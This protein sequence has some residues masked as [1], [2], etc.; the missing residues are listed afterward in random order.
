MSWVVRSISS[1]QRAQSYRPRSGWSKVW[2]AS[3]WRPT[4]RRCRSPW[5]RTLRPRQKKVAGTSSASRAS[6]T[7][8]VQSGCG[9][10]SKVNAT[11][12]WSPGPLQTTRCPCRG[13]WGTVRAD[14]ADGTAVEGQRGGLVEVLLHA[15]SS[16]RSGR[17]HGR[18]G[19]RGQ[20]LPACH[21]HGS[22]CYGEG[23]SIL[24]RAGRGACH[25]GALSGGEV[26][27]GSRGGGRASCRAGRR[28][29]RGDGR[30]RPRPAARGG[31]PP[32]PGP[33]QR[34][35]LAH[36][37][38]A[39]RRR[40]WAAGSSTPWRRA[41]GSPTGRCRPLVRAREPRRRPCVTSVV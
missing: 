7:R 29:C 30:P 1:R 9:P 25:T 34:R 41:S 4:L 32:P 38:R 16:H 35:G 6:S 18:P 28:R 15:H 33:A 5:S 27:P 19:R 8:G 3:S 13:R 21:L 40:R 14:G 37:L 39:W 17:P 26:E 24:R 10:S 36:E 20:G 11:R 2:L 23:A 12:R 31:R 22:R